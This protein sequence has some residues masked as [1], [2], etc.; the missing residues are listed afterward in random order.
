MSENNIN[1]EEDNKDLKQQM[2]E[3]KEAM[4]ILMARANLN[5]NNN[6]N[7]NVDSAMSIADNKY[8]TVTSLTSNILVL[9][10]EGYGRGIVKEFTEFGQT[11]QIMY[12][13]L[14]NIIYNQQKFAE[15][16]MFYVNNVDVIKNHDLELVYD[17]IL[18]HNQMKNIL[19]YD[20]DK[21]IELFNRTTK[22]QKET[23]ATIILR[24]LDKKENVD[25]N[26]LNI[27][28]REYGKDIFTM[29]QNTKTN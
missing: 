20:E 27:L 6:E 26:K 12:S 21:M 17:K 24:R 22:S 16:G 10:T 18:N 8:I 1:L 23:V 9:S 19:D 13:E 25:L 2:K 3:M 11:K 4:D 28:S 7:N 14:S 29:Y 5:S 15:N